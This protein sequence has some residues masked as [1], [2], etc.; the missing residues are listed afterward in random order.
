MRKTKIVTSF[1]KDSE[2]ILLL[3]RSEKVKSMKNL[4]A[5]ISGII[6][7]NEKPIKRAKIEILEEVGIEESDIT[8]M[9]E[10]N[11]ILIES[12]QYVNHQWEV[13]PFLF[14]CS[15]KEIKLN[16]ENSDSRWI[17]INELNNFTTVPSL[18]RVLARLF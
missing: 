1:L 8:L 9:K 12:P 16:W 2:K 10:G 13:Y 7:D 6:E 4:W 3:K 14:S 11:K 15:N 18:D 17:S 5:G